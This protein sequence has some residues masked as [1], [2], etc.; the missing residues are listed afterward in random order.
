MRFSEH[1][2]E[3]T[4]ELS[5]WSGIGVYR[6]NG[7]QL[8]ENWVEQD[9]EARQSQI[10]SGMPQAL[11]PPHIDPWVTT[12]SQPVDPGVE[13]T[14]RS[15]LDNGELRNAEEVTIDDSRNLG[16]A[17]SPLD[18][19]SVTLHTLFSAGDRAAF[20]VTQHGAY[21]GGLDGVSGGLGKPVDLNCVGLVRVEA[22]SVAA[23]HAVTG[24]FELRGQLAE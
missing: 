12:R 7:E 19:S 1:A 21:R 22:G 2:A 23:V 16:L 9:Y 4:G 17:A 18:V 20:H 8:L 11:E 3:P 10:D 13:D 14:L 24:R 5:C 6:W 15:W